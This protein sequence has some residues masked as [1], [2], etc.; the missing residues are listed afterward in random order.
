MRVLTCLSLEHHFPS[1]ILAALVCI[2]SCLLSL[3]L[4]RRSE[5]SNG[6]VQVAWLVI[7]A[8]CLSAGI[9]S[10][11]FIAMLGYRPAATVTLDVDQTALSAL[12]IVCGTI[13]GSYVAT[14]SWSFARALAGAVVGLS[15]TGMHYVGMAAYDLDALVS[16]DLRYVIAS[17]VLGVFFASLAFEVSDRFDKGLKKLIP[18]LLLALGVVSLHFTGMG[19]MVVIPLGASEGLNPVTFQILAFTTAVATLVVVGAGGIGYAVEAGLRE[20]SDRRMRHLALHDI[21]TNLPN[22]ACF[23]AMV[24]HAI[25]TRAGKR[26][27]VLMIDLNRFKEINDVW[28]HQAGDTVLCDIADRL[29]GHERPGGFAARLGGDEFG[30]VI[31]VEDEAALTEELNLIDSL[32]QTPVRHAD[33]EIITSASLGVALCPDDGEDRETLMRN[34]DLAMYKAKTD[35]LHRIQQ[36]EHALG[37]AVRQR[38]ELAQDLRRALETSQLK[39]HYQPQIDLKTGDVCGYEALV[40]WPHPV[41]GLVSPAEFIP[42]AEANGLIGRLGDWVLETT[43]EEV[44]RWP[45]SPKVAINLSAIQL[46]DPHLVGKVLQALVSTGLSPTQLE[47]ELTETA[48]IHDLRQSLSVLRRIKALGVSMAL[49]DFGTGYSALETLRQFPFDKIKLDKG[50]TDGLSDGGRSRAVI[51]AVVTLARNLDIPVLAEGVE[52]AD[53]LELLNMVGCEQ[54]QGY[55]IG[56]PAPAENGAPPAVQDVMWR[57][58]EP[59]ATHYGS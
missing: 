8:I 11:H 57:P 47:I 58:A 36:Y 41:R 42:L 5:R 34:A 20:R 25:E 21:V 32:F 15:V 52:T 33:F 3:R 1:V 51:S 16:W 40:R 54:A 18:G 56:R 9:W 46:N 35:P 31:P 30:I 13:V 59:A 12:I 7:T 29:R 55:L 44:A 19:A 10:T 17:V 22:R 4:Q 28:G 14:L 24:D 45:G 27:A 2:L 50:F 6:G 43:C 39:M 48:L 23:S 49:D 26:L 38:R 53:Q 37:E